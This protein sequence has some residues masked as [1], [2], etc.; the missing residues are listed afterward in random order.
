LD[1]H[2]E[3][4]LRPG[5]Q[6]D[7]DAV[8]GKG[9]EAIHLAESPSSARSIERIRDLAQLMQPY[10]KASAVRELLERVEGLVK[11]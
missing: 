4:L 11:E 8:A 10:V 3:A 9:I 1:L 2:T 6:R 7:L 5:K